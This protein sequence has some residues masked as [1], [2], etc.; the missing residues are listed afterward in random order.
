MADA[1]LSFGGGGDLP[2]HRAILAARSR[3]FRKVL[4]ARGAS[5]EPRV[6]HIDEKVL[7]RRFAPA[8]LHAAYTDQVDLSLIQRA[9]SSPTSTNSSGTS[10]AA[11][12][13]SG[14]RGSHSAQLEDAFQ[15]YEIA[16]FMEMPILAQGCEE[17]L[18][19][20]LSPATLPRLLRWAVQ[21]HASRYVHRQAM[22][23]LLDEFH[24]VMSSPHGPR[25]PRAALARALA[26]SELQCSEPQALRAVLRWAEHAPNNTQQPSK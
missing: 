22:R 25:V 23:Y 8:L 2:C 15:L 26:S 4:S 24:T 19:A 18:V 12:P 14:G 10:N 11:W 9:P 7:P 16:R 17:R 13:G 1:R 6:I 21:P 5:D 20:Q 3:L